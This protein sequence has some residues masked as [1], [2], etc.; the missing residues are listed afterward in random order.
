MNKLNYFFAVAICALFIGSCAKEKITPKDAINA[1][2]EQ[3][4]EV[5]DFM[6]FTELEEGFLT[7][8]QEIMEA[9][10]IQEDD[11]SARG[12]LPVIYTMSN[13][14]SGNQVIVFKSNDNNTIWE[15]ARY[16]TGGTGTGQGLGNQGALAF[17]ASK[18]LLYVANPGSNEISF[19]SSAPNGNLQL[20]GKVSSGGIRPVSLTVYSGV[21]Y[22]LNAGSDNI[23]GFVHNTYGQLVPL[24]NSTRSLSGTGTNPAQIS[25]A[26]NGRA[27]IVTE[28]TTNTI[29]T[30][31]M[32]YM[33]RPGNLNTFNSIGDT[34]FGFGL[35]Q[36]NS[37]IVAERG[38]TGSGSVVTSYRVDNDG[39]VF[40]VNGPLQLG[41]SG[42]GWVAI[43]RNITT[44]FVTNTTSN[45]ISSVSISSGN[46][47]GIS[48]F[49]NTTPSSGPLDAAMDRD[50]KY[51]YVLGGGNDAIITYRLTGLNGQLQQI[52]TDG[53]LPDRSSGIVVK[54]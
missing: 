4:T 11:A 54:N 40:L 12:H 47:L 20:M 41:T 14:V 52:D 7:D 15:A 22:V 3:L 43:N 49:G 31:A 42:A 37:F 6:E 29:S 33:G 16:A 38:G 53:G 46:Q 18:G 8:E 39:D 25:F 24:T 30:F 23:T 13:E 51:L 5:D 28:K 44:A 17:N 35:G 34:P 1:E 10:G 50:S 32:D 2:T 26:R 9:L 19:F 48:N 45:N 36:G 27:L 21:I